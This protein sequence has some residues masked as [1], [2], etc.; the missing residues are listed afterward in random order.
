MATFAFAHYLERLF[1]MKSSIIILIILIPLNGC[2]TRVVDD[3]LQED[4]YD[5]NRRLDALEGFQTSAEVIAASRYHKRIDNYPITVF[6]FSEL[7]AYLEEQGM[8]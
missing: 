7:D 3:F 5:M 8:T 2:S 6:A 4:P 1:Q